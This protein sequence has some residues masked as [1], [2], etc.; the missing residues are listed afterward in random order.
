MRFFN[1]KNICALFTNERIVLL[2]IALN[3]ILIFME[4]SGVG[5]HWI[6]FCDTACLVFFLLEMLCKISEAGFVNY[7]RS[8]WNCLDGFLVI[9]ALPTLVSAIFPI[10]LTDF[11]FLLIMRLFRV[12]RIFRLVHLFPHF[13]TI[14]KAFK[15][16]MKESTSLL[17]GYM[18]T[19]CIFALM[20]C[21]MFKNAAPQFFGTPFESIYSIFRMFTI[22]GWYEIPDAI[23]DNVDESY[24]YLVR[25]YFISILVLGGIIGMSLINSVFVDAMVSDN[26]DDVKAKLEELEKKIDKLLE[27]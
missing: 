5:G 21:A 10:Q 16:A 19:I 27:K 13:N 3:S 4:E 7:W 25:P 26:N 20:S 15:L 24:Q 18:I 17:L 1:Y 9:V 8:G 22:D 2:V 12:F 6:G 14:A 11:S 23:Y